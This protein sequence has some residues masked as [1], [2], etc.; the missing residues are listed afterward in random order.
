MYMVVI[1]CM[2]VYVD[3]ITFV[4]VMFYSHYKHWVSEY[5][6]IVPKEN[7]VLVSVNLWLD[8]YQTSQ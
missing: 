8:F 4:I 2:W 7:T 6:A 3:M 5:W 1:L